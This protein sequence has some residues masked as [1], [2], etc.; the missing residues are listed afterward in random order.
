[1]LAILSK[2]SLRSCI[3]PSILRY[4]STVII[5]QIP[6][7]F[8]KLEDNMVP[9]MNNIT[10]RPAI[11]IQF[12]SELLGL[13]ARNGYPGFPILKLGER[14]GPQEQYTLVRKLGWGATCST[15]L[16]RHKQ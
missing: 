11:Q 3:R 7:E 4:V 12:H 9:L 8:T 16:A 14:I 10:K 2:A 5:D 13:L 6:P 15:W 1:M